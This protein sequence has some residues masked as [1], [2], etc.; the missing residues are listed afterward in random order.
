[1]QN[2]L[3]SVSDGTTKSGSTGESQLTGHAGHLAPAHDGIAHEVDDEPDEFGGQCTW[4]ASNVERAHCVDD[5]SELSERRSEW[6]GVPAHETVVGIGS[7]REAH[8]GGLYAREANGPARKSRSPMPSAR[9]AALSPT[10]TQKLPTVVIQGVTV[11]KQFLAVG[12]GRVVAAYRNT[13]RPPPC[14]S[15]ERR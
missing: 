5:H 11:A 7:N 15:N 2:R 1:M 4:A 3:P 14:R 6:R 13:L 12:A 9:R 10:L 8:S